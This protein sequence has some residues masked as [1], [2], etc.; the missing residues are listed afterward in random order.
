[1]FN[2]SQSRVPQHRTRGFTLVELLVVIGIIA[3]L[4]SIL[5]PALNKARQS[6]SS[7]A[8]QSNLKQVGLALSMYTNQY[9]GSLPPG[10]VLE[11]DDATHYNWT[12]LL[13]GM[14]DKNKPVTNNAAEI[15][16]SVGGNAGGFRKVFLC[17]DAVGVS[18]ADFDP[19][20]PSVTH[21][22]SHPRLMPRLDRFDLRAVIDGYTGK[23][24]DTYK[25]T[26]LKRSAEIMMAF[27]GSVSQLDAA[28]F[29]TVYS[30]TPYL[31]PRQ[32][33]PVATYI[34][35]AALTTHATQMI[36]D[37]R[38]SIKRG[39]KLRITPRN[40][41]GGAAAAVNSDAVGND[42]NVRFR[43]N[44]NLAM[45]ALFADGHVATFALSKNDLTLSPPLGGELK[46]ENVYLDRPRT[47]AA[48]GRR[49]RITTPPRGVP[50][51]YDRPAGGP[52]GF[53]IWGVERSTP[54]CNVGSS[55]R[56]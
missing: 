46:A 42:W 1:M 9:K 16:A 54:P 32:G 21:Y 3:L 34:A 52:R 49:S 53:S 5:L 18:T 8:C 24:M 56:G 43:H 45:N 51:G 10:Y 44:R 37:P 33:I 11:K 30:G 41:S 47:A 17:P 39:M 27:D 15:A 20:D 2:D 50:P 31:R 48:R 6:A 7:L 22:L 55:R 29:R 40:A 36:F 26:R 23:P 12:S 38:T 14:M 28:G 25:V 4:I 13:V 35:D 19:N